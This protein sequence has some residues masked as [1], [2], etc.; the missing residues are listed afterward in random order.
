[1]VSSPSIGANGA[2]YFGSH[3]AKFY[4]LAPDGKKL[5]EFTVGGPILS[6]PALDWDGGIYFSSVDGFLYALNS[7]GGLR[8]RLL[9][10][11]ITESSPVIGL[12]GTIFIGV[13]SQLWAITPDG[14]K[15]GALQDEDLI[16]APPMVVGDGSICFISRY[17]L[18]KEA[19]P[20]PRLKWSSYLYDHGCASLAVSTSGTLYVAG[21]W[22]QFYAI[23][24]SS[25]LAA[26]PWPKFR[27][28]SRNTGNLN[29]LQR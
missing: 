26:T 15:K 18:V 22:N 8:W 4:A 12:D 29:D 1:V 28:N 19:S 24:A 7:T 27:G 3:D 20:E 2:I 25:P 10:G 16:E 5:W 23:R 13:N 21:R 11:G 9:T 14:K 17:G 6:S